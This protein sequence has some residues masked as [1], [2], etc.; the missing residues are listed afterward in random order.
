[1]S[2]VKHI[3][4]RLEDA[5]NGCRRNLDHVKKCL[6]ELGHDVSQMGASATLKLGQLTLGILRNGQPTPPPPTTPG[7]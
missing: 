1:M 2:D 5:L 3:G 7:I 6:G 4:N